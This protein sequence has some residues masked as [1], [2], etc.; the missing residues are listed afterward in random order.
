VNNFEHGIKVLGDGE[1][2]GAVTI[3]AHRFSKSAMEKITKAG[4]KYE[5]IQKQPKPKKRFVKKVARRRRSR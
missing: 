3:K 1:L 4:G 2:K 5:W